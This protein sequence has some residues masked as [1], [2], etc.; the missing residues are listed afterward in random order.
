MGL[1][2]ERFAQ[3]L[4]KLHIVISKMGGNISCKTVNLTVIDY[5]KTQISW[6]LKISNEFWLNE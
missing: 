3:L 5:D 2:F 4:A 6:K 1:D